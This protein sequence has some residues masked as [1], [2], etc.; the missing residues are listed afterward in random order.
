LK[1]GDSIYKGSQ[2]QYL[3]IFRKEVD[4]KYKLISKEKP[5]GM[6]GGFWTYK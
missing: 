3:L 4:G 6:F 1:I 5:T 2:Q